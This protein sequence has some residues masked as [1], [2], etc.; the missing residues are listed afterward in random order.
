MPGAAPLGDHTTALSCHRAPATNSD[1]TIGDDERIP[2]CRT[3]TTRTDRAVSPPRRPAADPTSHA[4]TAG[5]GAG[6]AAPAPT[7]VRTSSRRGPRTRARARVSTA[8]APSAEADRA[9]GRRPAA[10][11]RRRSSGATRAEAPGLTRVARDRVP[12][13]RVA[14]GREPRVRADR[15]RVDPADPRARI[16]I[17]GA[18]GRARRKRNGLVSARP[19]PSSRAAPAAMKTR[20]R[21]SVRPAS[22][23]RRPRRIRRATAAAGRQAADRAGARPA[24]DRRERDRPRPASPTDRP[25]GAAT[26]AGDLPNRRPRA[27]VATARPPTSCGSSRS[28]ASAKSART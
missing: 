11:A 21:G 12:P 14:P 23:T 9:A 26:A 18:P 10:S 28:G 16:G 2:E 1:D 24:I 7:R 20:R 5:V 15:P 22:R 13:V 8:R 3:T 19:G 17:R 6:A 25:A 4:G 27:S